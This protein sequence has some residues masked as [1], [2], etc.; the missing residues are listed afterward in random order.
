ML[1]SK[2]NEFNTSAVLASRNYNENN[3]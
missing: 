1:V 3:S 2:S